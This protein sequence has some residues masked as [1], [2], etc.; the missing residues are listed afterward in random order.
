MKTLQSEHTN[1][2][3]KAQMAAMDAMEQLREKCAAQLNAVKMQ[4][5]SMQQ[6]TQAKVVAYD[7]QIAGNSPLDFLF[8]GVS[9]GWV[10]VSLISILMFVTSIYA[11]SYEPM[12]TPLPRTHDG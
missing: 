3:S 9:S 2:M 8:V 7:Q 6:D 5:E 12:T 11:L 10:L 4:L 1:A